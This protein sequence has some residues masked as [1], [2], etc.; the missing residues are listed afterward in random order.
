MKKNI[1]LIDLTHETS[2]GLG[3]DMM[4]L[5]LGLIG[6]YC[7]K[8]HPDKQNIEIMKFTHE[9][10]KVIKENPPFI[11]AASNYLWNIDLSYQMICKVK[12]KYPETIVV[13]GG[14]NYPDVYEEQV[15]FIKNFPQ[16]D[17]FIY[18]DGEIPFSRLVG[19][20]L[21]N[22]DTEMVKKERINSVHTIV[23]GEPYFGELEPRLT[24]LTVIPSPYTMGLMDKFFDM[25]LLPAIQTNRGCPFL[26]TF[27]TEGGRYYTKVY[28]T[29]FERKKEEIDYINKMV[30]TT[31]TLRIT[32]SNLGM[33]KEDVEFFKYM[34]K[35]QEQTGYPE[36]IICSAGKNMKERILDCNKLVKGAMRLTASVQSLDDEVLKRIKRTNISLDDI[37]MLSDQVSDTDTHSYSEIILALPGDT[38]DS[39][40]QSFAG[41]MKAGISNITQHQLSLIYGTELASRESIDKYQLKTM[42]RPVQRCVGKYQFN[43]KDFHAIEIE[44]IAVANNT[45]PY[46][47]YLESRKLFLT[48]GLYYND[49]IFGEVHALLR[50]LNL[51]TWD[52][53][54]ILH[55]NISK[56]PECIQDIYTNFIR[57]TENEVWE[58]PEELREY[59]TKNLDNYI[60]GKIGGNLIYKSRG[61]AIVEHF[62]ELHQ[63]AFQYLRELLKKER[64]HYQQLVDDLEI[65]S[66]RQ[67]SD[68]FDTKVKYVEE[69]EFDLV[70]IIKDAS[71]AREAKPQDIQY[72]TKVLFA[73][74]DQ[75]KASIDQQLEF[76]GHNE[77]G[78]MKIMSHFPIKRFYRNT[79]KL[80]V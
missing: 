58:S 32:D 48:T 12:E 28:K 33:F 15:E 31:K 43:K 42:Y 69:F 27:C 70:K 41:L 5:Q 20:L 68:L 46:E 26:C 76:Y 52:W 66:L 2:A 40:K 4:P 67:K 72:K 38:L 24:D 51:N 7:L 29:S 80:E 64:I 54:E 65:Y 45:L 17:F 61:K 73:H 53:I 62:K 14:P 79:E 3:S 78:M 19:K 10:D 63:V 57:E 77:R 23:K 22:P 11:L 39:E 47:D 25:K 18:K 49:R 56:F 37:M 30:K 9:L 50:L 6:A 74:S 44:A 16:I 8:Q 13:I 21:E 35:L 34:A 60:S 59:V 55:K 36:Y 1:Y 75:Q 71:F